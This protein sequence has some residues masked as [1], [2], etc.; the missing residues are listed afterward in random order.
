MTLVGL[1][2]H[3]HALDNINSSMGLS[4]VIC[5]GMSVERDVPLALIHAQDENAWLRAAVQLQE[6]IVILDEVSE[7]SSE[8]YEKIAS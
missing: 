4:D 8:I 7:V 6:A 5:L 2:R 3:P 1:G